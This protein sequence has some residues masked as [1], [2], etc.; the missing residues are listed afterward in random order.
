MTGEIKAETRDAGVVLKLESKESGGL[1]HW[2]K[3]RLGTREK[4]FGPEDGRP[5]P[6]SRFA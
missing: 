5:N 6:S 3:T 4:R 2:R 1:E